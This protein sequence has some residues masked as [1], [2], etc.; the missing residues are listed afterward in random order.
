MHLKPAYL[1]ALFFDGLPQHV[2][3]DDSRLD[4]NV[5]NAT[6]FQSSF[7]LFRISCLFFLSFEPSFVLF[8]SPDCL[9]SFSIDPLS[10]ATPLFLLFLLLPPLS[11]TSFPTL[12]LI[13]PVFAV[14]CFS[15][16]SSYFSVRRLR[17]RIFS[18]TRPIYVQR[19][20]QSKF[21]CDAVVIFIYVSSHVYPVAL[22]LSRTVCF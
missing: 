21:L 7:V 1:R 13:F 12:F 22:S 6:H 3:V 20:P 9:F 5:V 2:F 10:G 18:M 11:F 16:L 4:G 14:H 8:L 15:P 19:P 17:L